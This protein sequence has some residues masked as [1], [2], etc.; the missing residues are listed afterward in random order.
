MFLFYIP[1]Q[2][3]RVIYSPTVPQPKCVYMNTII[4]T[5]LVS[6]FPE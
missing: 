2:P 4:C 5:Q 6:I 1:P 3:N